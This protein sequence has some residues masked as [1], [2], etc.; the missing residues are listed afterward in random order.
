MWQFIFWIT[1]GAVLYAYAGYPLALY[2]LTRFRSKAKTNLDLTTLPSVCLI[3]SAYNEEKVI[4]KK[5]ENS[6]ALNYPQDRFHIVVASDGSDDDTVAIARRYADFVT[7]FHEPERRGKS[8]VLNDVIPRL[9]A[10]VVVV[11]DANSL[12]SED[13]LIQLVRHFQDDGIGCVIGKLK[14]VDRYAT[15]VN[16]GEGLYWRYEDM[17]KVLESGLRSVLVANGSIFAI[18]RKL[19]HQLYPDIANDFQMPSDVASQGYGLLYEP[20][21]LAW[22]RSTMH[23]QEEFSRKVRII[24]RGLT[25]YFRLWK[26]FSALRMWQFVSHKVLRWLVGPLLAIN[27]VANLVLMPTAP[28]YLFLGLGQIAFYLA[29]ANG[30]RLSRTRKPQPLYY[31]PFYFTMVNLAATVALLKFAT[32]QRQRTWRKAESARVAPALVPGGQVRSATG[33]APVPVTN[34]SPQPLNALGGGDSESHTDVVSER[35]AKS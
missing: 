3:I 18:R 32:G 27:L 31:L 7:V 1:L 30:W 5:I 24:L 26:S 28:L 23:W 35:I 10:E 14:Y 15:S 4:E 6:I 17:L 19:F 34:P 8:A 11:T 2:I 21:A 16:K 25:G 13:A 29:A 33:G 12:F 9:D 22:E 20:G